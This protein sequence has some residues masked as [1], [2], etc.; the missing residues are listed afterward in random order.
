MNSEC[1]LLFEKF[2][3]FFGL[4]NS[5]FSIDVSSSHLA[6]PPSVLG[7]LEFESCKTLRKVYFA[8]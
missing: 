1:L 6:L 2:H 8:L 4:S 5:K 3:A 7:N